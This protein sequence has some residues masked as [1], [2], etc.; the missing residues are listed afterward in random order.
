[1]TILVPTKRVPDTDQKIRTS[2]DS[3]Q[4]ETEHIPFVINPFDAI[5]LEEAITIHENSTEEVDVVAVGV[6]GPDYEEQLRT[7][8]AMG[9][10]RALRVDTFG[11]TWYA[12]CS[13]Y[14]P[15]R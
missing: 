14:H 12:V 2:A 7:A 1:M 5:A 3:S 10:T 4:V 13:N 9:A 11:L 6:G 15:N 8:L